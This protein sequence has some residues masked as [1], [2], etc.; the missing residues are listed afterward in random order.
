MPG[1]ISI[2]FLI[3]ECSDLRQGYLGDWMPEM[4][5]GLRDAGRDGQRGGLRWLTAN[6]LADG[7]NSVEDGQ[8]LEPA[9]EGV[10]EEIVKDRA[11]VV[12]DLRTGVP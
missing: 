2:D 9:I 8:R 12:V 7:A 1:V 6:E 3:N 10:K 5:I 11:W 4:W